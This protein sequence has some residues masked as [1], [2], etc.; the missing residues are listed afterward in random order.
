MSPRKGD[1]YTAVEAALAQGL[2][3]RS[4][5]A[6]LSG[7]A[8]CEYTGSHTAATHRSAMDLPVMRTLGSSRSSSSSVIGGVN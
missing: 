3:N 7:F 1:K 5:S 6:C 2:T 4:S 8:S